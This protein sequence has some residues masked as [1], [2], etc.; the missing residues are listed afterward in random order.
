MSNLDVGMV[1]E[2]NG[3][4][5]R[6][7]TY[8][9]S[10]HRTFLDNGE[11]INNV[12]VNCFIV[13]TQGNVK[14]VGRISSETIWDTQSSPNNY[15]LDRRFQKNTIKRILD[16]Q[17]IGFLLKG[18]FYAGVTY[19]PMI[20][21]ICSI[22]TNKEI[23]QIYLNSFEGTDNNIT[24]SIG[25]SL[26]ERND[27]NLPINLFFASHIGIFGNTGSGK[28][29]T[30][31]KLYYELFQQTLPNLKSKSK[32][33]VLDFNGEYVHSNS[34]GIF[35]RE[36]KKV[37]ELSTR[38]ES[39][40]KYPIKTDTFYDE[41]ILA[42]LFHARSQTQKPFLSRVVKGAHKHGLGSSSI[43]KWVTYLLKEILRGEPNLDLR[44]R[45]LNTL[46]QFFSNNGSLEELKKVHIFAR[47][48]GNRKFSL[49]LVQ[50]NRVFFDGDWQE[51]YS[52]AINL[53]GI[54]QMI[55]ESELNSFQEFELRCKLQLVNDLLFGNVVSEFIDPLIKRIEARCYSMMKYLE[56]ND[57]TQY[58]QFLEIVSLKNLNQEAKQIMAMLIS[59]MY[60]DFNKLNNY[61]SSFHLIIDEAHN[62]LSSQS[63]IEND[64]WRDYRLSTFEEIIKEGRKFG[65][66]LTLSSQRPADISPT[67]LSQVHNFF[68][69]KLVNERDLQIVDNSL[70]TLD[71]VSKSMLP[72]LS[73]GVCIISGT[74]LSLPL[75]VNVDFIEDV[76]LRP[77][78]DTIN[79]IDT[80]S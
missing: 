25:K 20:G 69:H 18:K 36:E 1:V 57:Q 24:V 30:L 67:L 43:A 59:K 12:S 63:A 8:E 34:F 16:I 46:L 61:W 41:E 52:D 2:V 28:S 58:N 31:H 6:V 66:F 72:T 49:M 56:L 3:M 11:V 60:F 21:N 13:I 42:I 35:L 10:N 79:L 26:N 33:L 70:S 54:V 51:Y 50:G 15:N 73:Q 23:D 39:G 47:E 80:W 55:L 77:K 4:T 7:A 65:F 71:K 44:N 74:A 53:D 14:I 48:S 32:F 76:H 37:F 9:N 38:I 22:P 29:N 17:T 40:E 64:S 62:V 75:I 19:L 27:L 68:L 45:L 78:S 5:C